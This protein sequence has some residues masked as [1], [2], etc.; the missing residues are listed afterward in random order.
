M[1]CIL[2]I[3]TPCGECRMCGQGKGVTKINNDGKV[4]LE[5]C[6]EKSEKGGEA[7]VIE[8]GRLKGFVEA[9]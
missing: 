7:A 5:E 3:E 4:T 1:A 6:L 2:G 8:D 9:G